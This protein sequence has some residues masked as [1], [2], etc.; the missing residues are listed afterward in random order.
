M[1]DLVVDVLTLFAEA[2]VLHGRRRSGRAW[3]GPENGFI[4]PQA[5]RSGL[6]RS[7]HQTEAERK[8]KRS[9]LS[10]AGLKRALA[11]PLRADRVR[12]LRRERVRRWRGRQKARVQTM[13]GDVR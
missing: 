6:T 13:P 5:G 11:D 12:A 7:M 2:Q 8:A 1:T 10:C 9:A 3:V 4:L